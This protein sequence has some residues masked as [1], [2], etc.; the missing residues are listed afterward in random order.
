[1]KRSLET[2]TISAHVEAK[3]VKDIEKLKS[4]LAFAAKLE[5]ISPAIKEHGANKKVIFDKL[6]EVDEKVKA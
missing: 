5:K 2:T 6:K 1:M 4:S 3:M